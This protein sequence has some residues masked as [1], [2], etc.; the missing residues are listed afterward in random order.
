MLLNLRDEIKT[1]ISS[2]DPLDYLEA[3]H[4]H[5]SCEWIDSGADIFRLVK[6]DIPNIHLVSYFIVVD[7][8]AQKYL[9]VDHKKAGLWLPAGGHVEVNEHPVETVKREVKEELG[10]E[11]DF[12][13]EAPIFVSKNP[14]T[15]LSAGHMDISLWYVLKGDCNQA[16]QY[17]L[18]E[19]HAIAW[20]TENAIPYERSD[21]YMPRFMHKLTDLIVRSSEQN[22]D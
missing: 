8:T 9:L 11:A 22:Q 15:G 4:I 13:F 1:L 7:L 3:D 18:T 6:P 5:F 2:V 21:P 19:F 20:F 10:I 12:L 16:L 14:T 17:D